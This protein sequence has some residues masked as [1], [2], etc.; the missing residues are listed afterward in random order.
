VKETNLY[1][2]TTNPAKVERLR[3]VFAGL[4]LKPLPLPPGH[5]S[6]PDESGASF[7]ENAELKARYWSK[8]ISGLAAASDGGISIPALGARWD[9]LRTAR[10]AGEQADDEQRARH[11]LDLASILSGEQR[12]AFWSEAAALARNG[13]LIV[14]WLAAGTKAR[15]VEHIDSISLRPGFWAA[16]LCY[17]PEL[18]T[19]LAN[20]A[21][22]Q[23]PEADPTWTD[24]R[25][26]VRSYFGSGQADS[27]LLA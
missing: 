21:D 7:R 24:L 6:G 3:W 18:G 2:A 4:G 5:G 20:L 14:S 16:S 1:L 17:L 19:T 12:A 23:L 25:R 15:L 27:D 26:Q 22:E 11:L 13:R 10:A 9:A 8:Q